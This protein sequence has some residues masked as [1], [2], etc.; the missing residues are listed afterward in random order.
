MS[1]ESISYIAQFGHRGPNEFELSVPRPAEDPGWLDQQLAQFEKSPI[2]VEALLKKQ[3]TEFATAWKRFET[4]HPRKV[5]S[6]KRRINK[7]APKARLR[8]AVRS[9]YVRDR[10]VARTFAL[11]AGQLTGLGDDIFFL[12][13]E[14]VLSVLSG[15][16]AVVKYIPTRKDIHKRYSSLPAY[17]Q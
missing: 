8:E 13:I 5:R 4:S 2:D 7:V 10:W 3:R 15:D 17:R 6:M 11:R 1:D 9:E 16:Q 14:E 12:T